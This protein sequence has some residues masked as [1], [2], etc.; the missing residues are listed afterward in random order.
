MIISRVYGL[1][2]RLSDKFASSVN[3]VPMYRR[4][5]FFN[6]SRFLACEFGMHNY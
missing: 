2:K 3:L 1:V 5:E 6:H 4:L